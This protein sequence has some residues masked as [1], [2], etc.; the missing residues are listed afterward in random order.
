MRIEVHENLWNA[1]AMKTVQ[2]STKEL[3]NPPSADPAALVAMSEAEYAQAQ[4]NYFAR[5]GRYAGSLVGMPTSFSHEVRHSLEGRKDL[6][7][8]DLCRRFRDLRRIAH[9]D[10]EPWL[11]VGLHWALKDLWRKGEELSA[12][13]RTIADYI[14]GG[15]EIADPLIEELLDRS[16]RL[17]PFRMMLIERPDDESLDQTPIAFECQAEDMDHAIEQAENAYPGCRVLGTEEDDFSDG[18]RAGLS[19]AGAP[20]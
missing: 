18:A 13:A 7:Q 20:R 8:V 17:K 3:S 11:R 2:V 9:A 1:R 5:H 16:D 12:K 4:R 19:R 10:A 6:N 15:Q 14:V